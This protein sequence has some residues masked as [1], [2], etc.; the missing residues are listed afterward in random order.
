M[1]DNPF[2]GLNLVGGRISLDFANTVGARRAADRRDRLVGYGELV[3]WGSYA[4]VISEREAEELGVLAAGD[5]AGAERVWR[6]AVE[7]REAIY[8]IVSATSGGSAP[9]GGDLDLL[10]RELERAMTHVRV[11][12]AA[13]GFAWSWGG[14]EAL[15]RVL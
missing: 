3:S 8:R 10:N 12:A 7:L 2:P 13:E 11:V 1:R 5:P 6:R 9:G 14:A 15:D 4:G